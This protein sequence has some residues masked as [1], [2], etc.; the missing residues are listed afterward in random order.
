M[1]YLKRMNLKEVGEK[2]DKKDTETIERWCKLRNITIHED[3]SFKG[4]YIFEHEFTIAYDKPFVMTLM[5]KYPKDWK[6][7]Y[8]LYVDGNIPELI[9]I[10]LNSNYKINNNNRLSDSAQEILD[11]LI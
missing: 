10:Q 8:Q 2:L 11:N 6:P 7:I 5:K 4:K 1:F 3:I 9:E